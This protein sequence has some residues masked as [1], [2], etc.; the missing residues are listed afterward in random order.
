M[1]IEA[2]GWFM[3]G[4]GCCLALMALFEYLAYRRKRK[5]NNFLQHLVEE[6]HRAVQEISKPGER[7][8]SELSFR[9]KEGA[10][11]TVR[12]IIDH[13]LKDMTGTKEEFK[14]MILKGEAGTMSDILSG[15]KVSEDSMSKVQEFVFSP[16]AVRDMKRAGMEPDEVV[17]KML[18]ASGRIE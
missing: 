12:I 9:D 18:K 6:G 4:A 11:N 15:H 14:E 8:V 2:F 7:E 5:F 1:L 16:Q 13:D 17:I 10:M 3:L